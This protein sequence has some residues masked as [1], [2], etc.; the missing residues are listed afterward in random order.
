MLETA[1]RNI[2]KLNIFK[3]LLVKIILPYTHFSS[4]KLEIMYSKKAS[5]EIYFDRFYGDSREMYVFK[6]YAFPPIQSSLK[7][8]WRNF[9]DDSLPPFFS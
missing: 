9:K 4:F 8:Q 2:T 6:K 3:S 7:M 1:C 5:R